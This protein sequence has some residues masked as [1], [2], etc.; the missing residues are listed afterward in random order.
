MKPLLYV[1]GY[2]VIGAWAE[3]EKN[4]W[5]LD[6][7]RDRLIH[8]LEDYAGYT[9]QEVWLIFDG[10]KA[11]RPMR[12][13]EQRAGLTVVYTRHGETADHYIE[14]MCQLLPRYREA[15][16]ATSDGVEQTLILG[17]GATRLSARE[18]WRELG[19]ERS[20][21]RGRHQTPSAQQRTA[22]SSA[23]S[24]EQYAVLDKLRRQK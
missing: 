11:E 7:C 2:N 9:G 4:A 16:V 5:P 20:S 13:V 19:R 8:V 23:L 15:R 1:D 17:R 22:L 6:E 18:L 21:G 3:A 24:A 10:Y 14:R 12:S